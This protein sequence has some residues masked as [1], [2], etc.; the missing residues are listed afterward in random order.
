MPLFS[1]KVGL[2]KYDH[3]N[4]GLNIIGNTRACD[5]QPPNNAQHSNKESRKVAVFLVRHDVCE[6]ILPYVSQSGK[7]FICHGAN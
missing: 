7:G 3:T 1:N 5:D 4:D 2:G 6:V